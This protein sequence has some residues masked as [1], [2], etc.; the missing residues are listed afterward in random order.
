MLI[1]FSRRDKTAEHLSCP[2]KDYCLLIF[3]AMILPF[4]YT[5]FK[6]RPFMLV[7][8]CYWFYA[9]LILMVILF[10][11]YTHPLSSPSG[12]GDRGGVY[13]STKNQ[14]AFLSLT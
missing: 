2:D 4:S 8:E 9:N 14:N 7:K 11:L 6:K 12:E 10:N 5:I 13:N 1:D 3:A